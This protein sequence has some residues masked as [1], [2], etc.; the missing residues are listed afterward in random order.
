MQSSPRTPRNLN[1]RQQNLIA[2]QH[3]GT[4]EHSTAAYDLC[5]YEHC[6]M[7]SSVP[8]NEPLDSTFSSSGPSIV[9]VEQDTVALHPESFVFAPFSPPPA[10]LPPPPH[11]R[12]F[13][14]HQIAIPR[15][16]SRKR[17]N[18][19]NTLNRR[20]RSIQ[21][22]RSIGIRQS[23]SNLPESQ[24]VMHQAVSYT[25]W[26]GQ[27]PS[28]E[29]SQAMQS[30]LSPRRSSDGDQFPPNYNYARDFD[31]VSRSVSLPATG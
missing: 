3:T 1:H 14:A 29:Q 13:T 15:G 16:P 24:D 6:Q 25:L 23:P 28:I 12:H 5:Y 22:S 7:Q 2:K 31:S 9:K 19:V 4:F 18:T 8:F 10:F 20:L 21:R 17:A 27:D 11:A 26:P 30:A